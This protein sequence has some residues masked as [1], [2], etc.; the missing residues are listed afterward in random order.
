MDMHVEKS[1]FD[2]CILGMQ[3][4]ENFFYSVCLWF[5]V[6]VPKTENRIRNRKPNQKPKTESGTEN[7]TKNRIKNWK[8]KTE[9][10][11]GFGSGF[12]KNRNF[13]FGCGFTPKPTQTEPSTPLSVID[14]IQGPNPYFSL[15][16]KDH[17]CN[18]LYILL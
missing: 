7:R 1:D 2:R 9:K 5:M 18:F 8:P 3:K 6:L 16:H 17:I 4:I 11:N 13:R 10:P 14:E 15:N 12:S